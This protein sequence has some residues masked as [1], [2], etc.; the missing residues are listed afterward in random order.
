MHTN[1]LENVVITLWTT[2]SLV[3]KL[4]HTHIQLNN[5]VVHSSQSPTHVA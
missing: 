1:T 5:A 2:T 3:V 4:H